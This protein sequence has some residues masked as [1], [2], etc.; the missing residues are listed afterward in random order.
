MHGLRHIAMYN[1]KYL[2]K[3]LISSLKKQLDDTIIIGIQIP[4]D[5]ADLP[6]WSN[7]W[8]LYFNTNKY[9]VT[10]NDCADVNKTLPS[11]PRIGTRRPIHV[12]SSSR[13]SPIL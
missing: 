2:T 6:K 8:N 9:T 13:F 12:F 10:H 7:K 5:I 4:N 11:I 3:S 1:Y